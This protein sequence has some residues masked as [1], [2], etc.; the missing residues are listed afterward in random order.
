MNEYHGTS[1]PWESRM[2]DI[3]AH[4]DH[5]IGTV[6]KHESLCATCSCG[7]VFWYA[8]ASDPAPR[9]KPDVTATVSEIRSG[10]ENERPIESA[11][12]YVEGRG[13][14]LVVTVTAHGVATYSLVVDGQ[15]R[16]S[17][18]IT[19]SGHDRKAR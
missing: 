4:S 1:K 18:F 14:S 8:K 5:C 12:L 9:A 11:D 2:P 19:K 13:L 15:S 3:A 16:Q 17:G 10:E 6:T 7:A